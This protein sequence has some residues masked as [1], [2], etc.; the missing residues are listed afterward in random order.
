M[1]IGDGK[2]RLVACERR[3]TVQRGFMAVVVY[4]IDQY[5]GYLYEVLINWLSIKRQKLI[6]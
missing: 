2:I 3:D 1:E 4:R 5:K 6:N